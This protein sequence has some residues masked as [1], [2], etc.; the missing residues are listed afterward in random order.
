MA[1]LTTLV[2]FNGTNGSNPQGDLI[3]DAAG[4]L[5]G[6]AC[7]GGPNGGS[8][9]VFEIAKT[10]GGYATTPITLVTFN[11]ANGACPFG[12]VIAD[13]AGNLFGMTRQGGAS[14]DGTVFE[15]A[16]TAGGYAST[17]TVLVSFNGTNGTWPFGGLIADAAGDLFGT[18]GFGGLYHDGTVFEIA[19]T[20]GGYAS[21]PTT[22]GSFNGTNGANPWAGLIADAAGD[23]FGAT[24]SGGTYGYGT[25]FEITKTSDAYASTPAVLV[26]FNDTDGSN[27]LAALIADAAGDLFGTTY[28]GGTNEDG[29]VFEIAKVGGGYASTPTTLA[30]FNGA[31]GGGPEANLIIDAAGDLFGTTGSGGASGDGTVFEIAKTAGGYASTPTTL[32]TFNYYNGG[33][34]YIA[35]AAGNLFGTTYSG[36]GATG[37]GTAFELSNTGFIV[38]HQSPNDFTGNGTSD[39]LF[40]DPTSGG[41][42]DFL[43]NN[44]Q[45][46]WASIGWADPGWQVAGTGDFNGDGTS[47]ILLHDA[48]GGG[49]GEFAM[50]NNQPTWVPI[51]W[52][53]PSWQVAG[54]GDFNGDGT[55]DILLRDTTG[56]GLGEFQ[57]HDNQPTWVS[58]GWVP[59]SWTVVGVGDFDG[60]GTSDILFRDPTSG[61]LSDLL[62]KNG[63]PTWSYIGW[64]GTDWQV[65]GIGDFNG[66]GTSDILFRD[67]TSGWLGDFIMN[68][69]QSTWAPI[70]W[71][72]S[73]QVAAVGDYNGD[74]T[75]DIL[76]RDPT[77]GGLS[78]FLMHNNQSTW[79]N[80]GWAPTN[81][82]V[83]G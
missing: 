19:K 83:A 65:A 81:W 40:R 61:A 78:V 59:P 44:G 41:I 34:P 16:K 8:G 79:A 45:P 71:A 50:N 4:D 18:T 20:G 47:D 6:T 5:F 2:S 75:S 64:A 9:T 36:G 77:G 69:G 30:S 46:T 37:D 48:T 29:T 80:A 1:T 11:G 68:N 49:I 23:L 32:V 62:M 10:A 12:G 67:P 27:P 17:P 33:G 74:G 73:L 82:Q 38:A 72:G 22:L 76:L 66:D 70:G 35:D 60:D 54:V 31:D 58:I 26:S 7:T 55:S 14:D 56:G 42:G 15:I 13:A 43:M 3:A 57:M 52:A 21:T 63:Q 51:G 28:S 39:I 24:E 53:P 25:V